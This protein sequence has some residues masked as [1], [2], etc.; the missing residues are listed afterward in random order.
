MVFLQVLFL[1]C[2]LTLERAFSGLNTWEGT[3]KMGGRS[4][5]NVNSLLALLDYEEL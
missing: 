2:S 5:L 1:V 4:K 3:L